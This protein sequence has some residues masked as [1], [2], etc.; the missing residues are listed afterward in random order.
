[1]KMLPALLMRCFGL[2]VTWYMVCGLARKPM[3]NTDMGGR[4]VWTADASPQGQPDP[5]SQGRKSHKQAEVTKVK[6][7]EDL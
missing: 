1:M 7:Q 4:L 3:L 6:D 5:R 2:Q